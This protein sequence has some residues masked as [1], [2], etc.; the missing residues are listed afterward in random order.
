MDTYGAVLL[1]LQ[2]PIRRYIRISRINALAY[3]SGVKSCNGK[4]AQVLL[5]LQERPQESAARCFESQ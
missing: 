2:E 1:V 4:A 3:L 5:D